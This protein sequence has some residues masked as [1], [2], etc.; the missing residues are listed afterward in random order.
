MPQNQQDRNIDD[1]LD[2]LTNRIY[3]RQR[4]NRVVGPDG[5]RV[6]GEIEDATFVNPDNETENIIINNETVLD[7]GHTGN[8]G[9]RCCYCSSL[10]CRSCISICGSCGSAICP[11]HTIIANFNNGQQ[12]YCRRCA[13][14]INR[15][16]KLRAFTNGLL[17]FFFKREN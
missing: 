2:L 16:L 4:Q 10:V 15:S 7:C 11:H 3:R 8:P 17:S 14:K 6:I 12:P 5:Y 13:E 9:G 1:L